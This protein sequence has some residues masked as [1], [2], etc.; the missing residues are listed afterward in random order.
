MVYS[1]LPKGEIQFMGNKLFPSQIIKKGT[2]E[3]SLLENRIDRIVN[4]KI[5]SHLHN[6]DNSVFFATIE[7]FKKIGAKWTNLPLTT[8]MISSPG[9]V[10]AGQTL[11]Y[12]TDTLPIE[13]QNRFGTGKRIFLAESSQF[14]L[15]LTLLMEHTEHVFSIYNSFRKEP[16][17]L[18][19]LSEFQHIEYEGKVGFEKNINIFMGL[20]EYIMQYIFDNNMD[21]LRVFLD[22][23]QIKEKQD[24]I[25]KGPIRIKF[26]D[27]LNLLYNETKDDKYK[28]FTMKNFGSWE[29]IKLTELL[30]GNVIVENFPMLQIP[31]YHAIAEEKVNGVPV[32]RNADFILYGYRETIGSGERIVDK[33]TLLKKADI[34]NLPKADYLPYVISRDFAT[35]KQTSGFGM[36][37]QRLMQ[38]IT[39]QPYIYEATIIPRTHFIP[40]P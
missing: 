19:H 5:F 17:D 28:E 7:Y 13:I 18:T 2:I 21:D 35:Y 1:A 33:E 30:G 40:N 15:E 11:D 3:K 39:N 9:E 38:W 20:F 4:E 8:L 14:Y 6:L 22:E 37:W 23:Q 31:F 27:A 16:S 32:A 29:E 24:I 12:T 26:T 25:K 36:G 10:Y 34:F